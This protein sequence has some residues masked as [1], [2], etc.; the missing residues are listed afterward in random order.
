MVVDVC[1]WNEKLSSCRCA[2]KHLESSGSKI[3]MRGPI[4]CLYEQRET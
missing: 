1:Y 4:V 2:V 3:M